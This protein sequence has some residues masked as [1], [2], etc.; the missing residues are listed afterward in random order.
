MVI[1]RFCCMRRGSHHP[2]GQF[3]ICDAWRA[4]KEELKPRHQPID[5]TLQNVARG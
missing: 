2:I 3:D 1:Y 5:R 4:F